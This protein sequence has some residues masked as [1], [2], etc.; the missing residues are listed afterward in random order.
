MCTKTQDI[1]TIYGLIF[2]G[3][4]RSHPKKRMMIEDI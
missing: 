1:Y 2:V 3:I 4:L